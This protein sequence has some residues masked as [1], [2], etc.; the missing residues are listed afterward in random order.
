V[1]SLETTG[2]R[3]ADAVITV[4]HAMK[5]ELEG[6]GVPGG[7]IKVCYHGVDADLFDPDRIDP[8][9][10]PSSREAMG[11]RMTTL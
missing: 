4:S 6:M 1:V 3:V 8:E 9:K 2:A 10:L 11:F 7:K 5:G